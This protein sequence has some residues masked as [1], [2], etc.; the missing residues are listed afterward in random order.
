VAEGLLGGALGA[1]DERPEGEA[2][3][4]VA[5]AEAFAAAIAAIAS[6]QDPQVARDTST[7][8]KKQSR[9]LDIQAQHLEDEHALRLAHLHNLPREEKL[10]RFSL[11]LRVGFQIFIAL[12]L[13]LL[14]LGVLVMLHDVFTSRGVVVELFEAP[15]ALAARGMTGKVV[16]SGLLDELNSLQAATRTT[17]AKRSLAN[18]WASDVKLA[19]PEA[20]ISIGELSRLL[21]ARFGHDLHIDGD[22][23]ETD[24]GGFALSVRGD[25]VSPMTFTGGASQLSKLTRQAAE[26]VYAQAQP[27]AWA[28]Y[29]QNSARYAEAIAFCKA[30]YLAADKADRPSLLNTWANSLENSGGSAREALDLYKAS[31]RMQPDFWIAHNNIMNALWGLADEEGA[32][33]AGEELRRIAGGR[34]GRAPEIFFQNQDT[35]T[36]NLP[37]WLASTIAD[38]EHNAGGGSQFTSTGVGV[39]EIY[40]RMHDDAA[41]RLAM[42]TVKADPN[43]PTIPAQ[44]HFARALLA[45]QAGDTTTALEEITAYGTAFANPVVS[46]NFPGYSCW[47]APIQ[48]AAGHREAADAALKAGGSY[49]DCYRFRADIL[50]GRGDWIGAQRAYAEAV[51]LAP[52]L[53]A[54]YYS[55]GLALARH[56][57]LPGAE[58]KLRAANQRGPHW[59]DP[60]KAWADVLMQQGHV[61][62]ALSKYD[63]ALR[64]APNWAALNAARD[65]AAKQ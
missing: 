26:H 8:L 22:L 61:R 13:S 28:T 30:A 53:P 23:V 62:N 15:P 24:D 19:L 12:V 52:D 27:A 2:P 39:A 32:W 42:N 60:L 20:G 65:A 3:E 56:G 40:A 50:D 1:E 16:A 11:R 46:S 36:W 37:V 17:T 54:G 21:K 64:Y 49:V 45:S 5:A 51:A 29:L 4:P 9:L 38:T 48:E 6:R 31:A 57:D 55:W 63:D 44:M 58:A 25:G 35:M 10:R 41:A 18:A 47:I 14:G 43:D 59:A 34:P 7:F 33:K